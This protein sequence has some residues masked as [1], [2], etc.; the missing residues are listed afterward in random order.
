[1]LK[2]PVRSEDGFTLLEMIVVLFLLVA[3]LG[4][5][6]PR[7]DL[8]DDLAATGRKFIGTLRTLQGIAMSTQKPIKLYLDLDQNR[9]WAVTMEEKEE[10]SLP[11]AAWA[12]PRIFP[13]TI[14]LAEASS[15]SIKRTAGRLDLMLYPNGRIDEAIL[16]LADTG[17]NILA[18]IVEPA[19]GAIRTSDQRVEFQRLASIPD[20]VKPLLIPAATVA[21]GSQA[22]LLKP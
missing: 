21:A 22:G 11:D 8:N 13:E 18:I 19:T 14:R 9:Y 7:I 6:I 20:R 15:G 3:M 1:M 12:S 17:N 16:Y 2:R 10:K 5:V 4:I